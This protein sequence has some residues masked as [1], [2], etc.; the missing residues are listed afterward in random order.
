[1]APPL[2][3]EFNGDATRSEWHLIYLDACLA[4]AEQTVVDVFDVNSPNVGPNARPSLLV[5]VV[6]AGDIGIAAISAAI[7]EDA[8]RQAEDASLALGIGAVGS[9]A[10][11]VVPTIVGLVGN[12]PA[13]SFRW[14]E[15][16]ETPDELRSKI[17]HWLLLVARRILLGRPGREFGDSASEAILDQLPATRLDAAV[18]RADPFEKEVT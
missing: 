1:M 10:A 4:A 18:L 13:G 12:G 3:V 11:D 7:S 17:V 6:A 15:S 16:A 2:I 5:R 9:D 8:Q 14:I